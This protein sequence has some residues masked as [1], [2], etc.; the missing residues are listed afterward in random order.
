M[1]YWNDTEFDGYQGALLSLGLV[2]EDGRMLYLVI[3]DESTPQVCTPWVAEHVVP[4]LLASPEPAQ[5]VTRKQARD[6]LTM[7][8]ANDP[9]P[10]IT[11]D[12]PDDIKYFCE[13]LITGP[14]TMIDIPGI[15]FEVRR[16]D[17][18]PTLLLGAVQHNAMWDALALRDR[19]MT[20][21]IESHLKRETPRPLPQARI[22]KGVV[23]R[24][25]KLLEL[26]RDKASVG[27][28]DHR[29]RQCQRDRDECVVYLA[30]VHGT[31][32]KDGSPT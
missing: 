24:V 19:C 23:E 2:A 11:V 26:E 13:L 18:Y 29:A 10:T 9:D 31:G 30:D 5:I 1:N 4:F 8:F 17:A 25:I 20:D 32:N 3:Q 14:G 22:P 16:V 6:A 12:W 27:L 21:D 15:K 7:F 28:D